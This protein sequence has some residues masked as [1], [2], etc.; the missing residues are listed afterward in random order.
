MFSFVD[1]S[2]TIRGVWAS[3]LACKEIQSLPR[4]FELD[5]SFPTNAYF[6]VCVQL[7]C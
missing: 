5:S 7:I 6:T 3:L 1:F 4:V 2:G